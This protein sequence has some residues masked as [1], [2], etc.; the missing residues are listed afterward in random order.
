MVSE[1]KKMDAC[2]DFIVQ[3]VNVA[4]KDCLTKMYATKHELN[5]QIPNPNQKSDKFSSRITALDQMKR[6]SQGLETKPFVSPE[7]HLTLK[8]PCIGN[9]NSNVVLMTE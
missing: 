5:N 3:S 1:I 6:G 7:P 2:L 4:G 8:L 9:K